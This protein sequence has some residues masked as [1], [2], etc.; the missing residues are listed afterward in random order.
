VFP[1]HFPVFLEIYAEFEGS[2]GQLIQK[3]VYTFVVPN[4]GLSWNKKTI[5]EIEE[6]LREANVPINPTFKTK[7]F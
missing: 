7:G 3:R 4:R 1:A 5:G 2:R 6:A